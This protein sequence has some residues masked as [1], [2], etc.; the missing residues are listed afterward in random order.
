MIA[1]G[2]FIS[3][4]FFA[5]LIM[6]VVLSVK[7]IRTSHK[8]WMYGNIF[9]YFFLIYFVV[10]LIS[11]AVFPFIPFHSAEADIYNGDVSLGIVAIHDEF[12]DSIFN[13]EKPNLNQMEMR[14][15]Y[16][17]DFEKETLKLSTNDANF[18]GTV[19]VEKVEGL[20]GKIKA[21]NYVIPSV[22]DNIL[23]TDELPAFQLQWNDGVISIS[24]PGEPNKK[25]IIISHFHKEFT[26]TQFTD[27]PSIFRTDSYSVLGG[28]FL[29]LQVP[30]NVNVK[31]NTE[32]IFIS[33]VK[34]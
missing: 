8:K 12:Y 5:I 7:S 30:E 10:L 25:E 4:M 17:W 18:Y 24:Q 29:Y 34:N 1:L 26:I 2:S 21:E 13:N 9:K 22:I 20:Q 28:A 19:I 14:D 32:N 15:S 31:S 16:E 11:A 3:F 33:Y 23:I 27:D 6:L